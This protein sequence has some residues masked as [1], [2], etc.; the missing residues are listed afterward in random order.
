[1]MQSLEAQQIHTG[2]YYPCCLHL[3]DV[4]ASLPYKKEISQ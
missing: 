3:Q 4:Y 1:M 2:V